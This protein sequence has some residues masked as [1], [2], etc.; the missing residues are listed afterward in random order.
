MTLWKIGIFA[1]ASAA[2]LPAAAMEPGVVRGQVNFIGSVNAPERL[3][4]SGD[5]FC[6]KVDQAVSIL[7]DDVIVNANATLG[8]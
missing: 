8:T 2:A 5:Q 4:I 7:Q 6:E 3:K 1:L